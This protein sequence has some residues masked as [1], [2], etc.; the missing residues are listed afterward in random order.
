[1]VNNVFK[2]EFKYI[3]DNINLPNEEIRWSSVG[4]SNIVDKDFRL[5]ASVYD[6]EGKTVRS[7]LSLCKWELTT[8]SGENGLS[9]AYHRARFKR[10]WVEKSDYPIYQPSQ[11]TEIN[12]KPT[13]FISE[14]TNTDIESLRVKKGQLLLTCSGTIG[15]C[16]V[17]SDS[18]DN[19]IF[20][21]DLIRINFHSKYDC[22]YTYAF[23]K[24]KIGKVLL[25]TNSYGAVI[26]HIEPE[27]LDNIPI[28]NPPDN[29]K[30]QIHDDIIKSFELR[31]LSNLL[32][33]EAESILITE[34]KLPPIEEMGEDYFDCTEKLR[35]YSVKL[36]D[37]NLRI[38]ASNH[39]PIVDA[40]LTHL[41]S[42][43]KEVIKVG[44]ERLS[45]AVFLPGRFKRIYVE[46]GQGTAFFGG[47]QITEL[48]PSADKYLSFNQHTER[49][50]NELLL[51]EN[52][53]L[54]S[55]SGTIGKLALVPKHWEGWSASEDLIRIFPS[56]NKVAGYLYS[57][58]NS[59]YGQKIIE[60]FIYG[61]VQDHVEDIHVRQIEI[62]II[63]DDNKFLQINNLIL[64]ANSNR[65]EAYKLEQRAINMVYD[66]VINK[67]D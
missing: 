33:E 62:P 16:T 3:Q 24:T 59:P 52:S 44:D 23:L 41:H 31:D 43:S 18:L 29:I 53:I 28:P 65:F 49:L 39:I 26:S 56:S 11:V 4:L 47:K 8:I 22:G 36:S 38:D 48:A 61:S 6:I 30:K 55:R 63:N 58:L 34:L 15:N 37:L 66:E 35:S 25:N 7:I 13:N 5:E 57:F 17:V 46:E 42:N 27:H 12:P 54:I 2:N 21:H 67:K 51:K 1:M 50:K 32:I 45:K 40:L 20:S 10:I 9:D 60:R 64:E 14:K 19:K